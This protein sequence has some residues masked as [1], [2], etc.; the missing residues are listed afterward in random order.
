MDEWRRHYNS[1]DR[2][3]REHIYET[4]KAMLDA[5][6][7]Q[8]MHNWRQTLPILLSPGLMSFYAIVDPETA[9]R[10]IE[11]LWGV[12][13]IVLLLGIFLTLYRGV[14]LHSRFSLLM[15]SSLVLA[16]V[17]L[18]PFIFFVEISAPFL[19]AIVIYNISLAFYVTVSMGIY[20]VMMGI[21]PPREPYA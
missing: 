14:R 10:V 12:F 11:D 15:A 7:K 3:Q 8:F 18:L 9:G 20:L 2:N 21:S 13:T 16:I 19:A 4:A 5:A 6:S 1:L 17:M